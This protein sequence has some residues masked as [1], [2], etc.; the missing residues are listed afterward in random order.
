MN[1]YKV[2]ISG[3]AAGTFDIYY[4]SVSVGTQLATGV[5]RT[6][7]LAGYD[8]SNVPYTA[9]SIIVYNSDTECGNY[10]TYLIKP[11]TPTPTVTPTPTPTPTVVVDCTLSG[12]SVIEPTPL[13]TSTPTVT[14][15]PTSTPT[16][17]PT[18]TPTSYTI[19][20]KLKG[21]NATLNSVNIYY[22]INAGS[23]TLYSGS[24][25]GITTTATTAGAGISITAGD[26]ISLGVE[27]SDVNDAVFNVATT[28]NTVYTGYC[29]QL[30]P[31]V[32]TPGGSGSY[33][34]N[35]DVTT[36]GAVEIC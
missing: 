10:V 13:P 29:G 36:G 2:F 28:N 6:S 24:P 11:P 4:D 16:V 1:S 35:V 21:K 33:F 30:T 19:D 26:E 22:K 14:P 27:R 25:Y 17:T 15:T 8:V 20:F 7:L 31:Y 9:T 5:S 23:W 3:D 32:T 34:I 12:G 18:P